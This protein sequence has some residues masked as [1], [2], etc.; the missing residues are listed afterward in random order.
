MMGEVTGAQRVIMKI[1]MEMTTDKTETFSF[2]NIISQL[3]ECDKMCPNLPHYKSMVA[4]WYNPAT[5]RYERN[6]N[7]FF[8]IGVR[9]FSEEGFSIHAPVV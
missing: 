4:V 3:Y 5:M 9:G 8:C 7:S 1:V 2:T 6:G